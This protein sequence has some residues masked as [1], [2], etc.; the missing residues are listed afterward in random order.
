MSA[1]I[2]GKKIAALALGLVLMSSVAGQAFAFAC[3][4]VLGQD[5]LERCAEM[6]HF[7]PNYPNNP[8]NSIGCF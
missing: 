3:I 5:A 7:D 8:V 4:D 2:N 6:C 1:V